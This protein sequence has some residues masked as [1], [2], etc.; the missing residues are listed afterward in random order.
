M[1]ANGVG[2][3]PASAPLRSGD[4]QERKARQPL[5]PSLVH[6]GVPEWEIYRFE[7]VYFDPEFR[8]WQLFQ[9][10]PEPN[11]G[12]DHRQTIQTLLQSIRGLFERLRFDE[13]GIPLRVTR[14]QT[15][16][17][18]KLSIRTSQREYFKDCLTERITGPFVNALRNAAQKDGLAPE[19][20]QLAQK[21][22]EIE[23]WL[24]AD[25]QSPLS[26]DP[27]TARQIISLLPVLAHWDLWGAIR[28][29]WD[30][31]EPSIPK[32]RFQELGRLRDPFYANHFIY[33]FN[34]RDDQGSPSRVALGYTVL[35]ESRFVELADPKPFPGS[36]HLRDYFDYA[37][38]PKDDDLQVY[39]LY[40]LLMD[41]LQIALSG[42]ETDSNERRQDHLYYVAYPIFSSLGR[43]HWLQVYTRPI[44]IDPAPPAAQLFDT[45]VQLHQRV[46]W[47]DLHDVLIDELEQVD[48]VRFLKH[49]TNELTDI[50]QKR[51]VKDQ[52]GETLLAGLLAKHLHILFP[53][54]AAQGPD[55]SMRQ[56][57]MT[58]WDYQRLTSGSLTFGSHWTKCSEEISFPE[59]HSTASATLAWVPATQT[60]PRATFLDDAQA[61]NLEPQIPPAQQSGMNESDTRRYLNKAYR[62]R[63]V[64]RQLSQMNTNWKAMSNFRESRLLEMREKWRDHRAYLAT[65]AGEKYIELSNEIGGYKKEFSSLKFRVGDGTDQLR[66]SV[67]FEPFFYVEGLDPESPEAWKRAYNELLQ[68]NGNFIISEFVETGA[69]F[70]L[71]HPPELEV[72]VSLD[73]LKHSFLQRKT[74]LDLFI[75]AHNGTQHY[76]CLKCFS[77]QASRILHLPQQLSRVSIT[78]FQRDYSPEERIPCAGCTSKIK[79]RTIPEW[80]SVKEP[81][82]YDNNLSQLHDMRDHAFRLDL[83]NAHDVRIRAILGLREQDALNVAKTSKPVLNVALASLK[84]WQTTLDKW[85]GKSSLRVFVFSVQK[86]VSSGDDFCAAREAFR[87]FIVL[88]CQ[89]DHEFYTK[90]RAGQNP[91]HRLNEFSTALMGLGCCYCLSF[92]VQSGKT[93]NVKAQSVPGLMDVTETL[94]VLN[95]CLVENPEQRLQGLDDGFWAAVVV[96]LDRVKC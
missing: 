48:L 59:S 37:Y 39:R 91:I 66:S 30:E 80:L 73:M 27:S 81:S 87:N 85:R 20:S 18:L 62:S 95:D 34:G 2:P 10:E 50:Q 74:T 23:T 51:Y 86:S 77:V 78:D 67:F 15:A 44:P 42:A 38:T 53:V 11:Q 90:L 65:Q 70:W 43:R 32:S 21:L 93:N 61:E 58:T 69:V 47:L 35:A 33:Q 19:G 71:T 7:L 13:W 9:E 45:F 3:G 4:G 84:H 26:L 64:S 49:T 60:E 72:K 25:G 14:E 40:A 54:K 76:A 63:L 82:T 46:P 55:I 68:A 6:F 28:Q 12:D 79:G 57:G 8:R 89:I 41:R 22:I 92:E 31:M 52:D 94:R 1:E 17:T 96:I 75:E 24:P 83:A 56:H 5:P 29:G 88:C 36:I 16:G